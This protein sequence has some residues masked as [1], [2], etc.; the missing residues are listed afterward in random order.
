MLILRG[1]ELLFVIVMFIRMNSLPVSG[2]GLLFGNTKLRCESFRV[3][4]LSSKSA[5]WPSWAVP[6]VIV[7]TVLGRAVDLAWVVVE[8][9]LVLARAEEAVAPSLVALEERQWKHSGLSE[10]IQGMGKRLSRE[11]LLG[12]KRRIYSA[13]NL[14]VCLTTLKSN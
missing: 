1:W 12:S 7:G 11:N 4:V 3:M 14:R 5:G 8:A 13:P 10:A 2:L 6:M 9:S